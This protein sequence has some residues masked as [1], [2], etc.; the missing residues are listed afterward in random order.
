[1]KNIN[2]RELHD[3]EGGATDSVYAPMFH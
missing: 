1:M 2:L 3:M